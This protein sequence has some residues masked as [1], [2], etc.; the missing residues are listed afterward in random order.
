MCNIVTKNVIGIIVFVCLPRSR[1][2]TLTRLFQYVVLPLLHFDQQSTQDQ[3]S[4]ELKIVN[5]DLTN[6]TTWMVEQVIHTSATLK[7]IDDQDY[8]LFGYRSPTSDSFRNFD[9]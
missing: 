4:I 1:N 3:F 2:L 9:Q 6:K 8:Q 7:K 5:C